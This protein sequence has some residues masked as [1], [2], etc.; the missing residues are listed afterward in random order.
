MAQPLLLQMP[1][2]EWRAA[3]RMAG[4]GDRNAIAA[5]A[6]LWND[7][8]EQAIHCFLCQKRVAFPPFS[9]I[10]PET[11]DGSKI[12]I[13]P[14]CPQCHAMPSALRFN[15]CLALVKEM[16]FQRKPSVSLDFSRPNSQ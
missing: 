14:I 1:A 16:Y 15:K 12:V 10:L 9:Q 8:R 3:N 7:Y 6:N 5:L 2:F 4:R 11:G 13:A